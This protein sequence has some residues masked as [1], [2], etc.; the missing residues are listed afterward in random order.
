MRPAWVVA[1]AGGCPGAA[2]AV[3]NSVRALLDIV[4]GRRRWRKVERVK[5]SKCG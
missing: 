3:T 5:P 4:G 1:T 2:D